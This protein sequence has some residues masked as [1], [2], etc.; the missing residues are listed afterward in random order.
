[1][2]LYTLEPSLCKEMPL[3]YLGNKG[4]TYIKGVRGL[5]E[6]IVLPFPGN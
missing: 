4:D 5:C 3:K 2:F 1:M 6:M